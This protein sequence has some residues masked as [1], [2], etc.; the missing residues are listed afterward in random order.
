MSILG[1]CPLIID[2]VT[3]ALYRP[4]IEPYG[5]R[6]KFYGLGHRLWTAGLVHFCD[7][8]ESTAGSIQVEHRKPKSESGHGLYSPRPGQVD[9]NVGRPH[10]GT[11]TRAVRGQAAPPPPGRGCTVII[12]VA[13]SIS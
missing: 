8:V 2:T 12:Q 5:K 11:G 7:V 10:D 6:R 4:I 9:L 3:Y 1:F 13:D